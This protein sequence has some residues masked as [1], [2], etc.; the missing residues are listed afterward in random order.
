MKKYLVTGYKGF[1]GSKLY[2]MLP[3]DDTVGVDLKDGHDIIDQLPNEKVEIV[4]HM[5]AMPSVE[6]SVKY[7]SYTLKHNVLGTSKVLEWARKQ[8]AARVIFSSSA[9]IY[10]NGLGPTSPYGLHKLMSEKEC[11][12]Y[13]ELYGLDT[14]C[15][16][17][18]NVYSEDQP[19]SGA[20]ST[21]I[22]AWMEMLRQGKPLRIDGDG[23]QTRDYVHVEDVISANMFC[24]NYAG[25]FGGK[26]Y[27][28]ATGQN[29]SINNLKSLISSKL[30]AE[31]KWLYAPGRTGDVKHSMSRTI[32]LEKIG[33]SSKVK[34][35]DGLKKCFEK[36][37][38]K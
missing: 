23:D 18:F 16:R 17:Y 21:V 38:I 24:A 27:D 1:I 34:I 25:L 26:A 35:T 6:Y 12:L 7:P 33:W 13:T 5:A 4:F 9:A 29:T 10:G 37:I 36:R 3:P 11:K 30:G 22:S 28:V 14:V 15:L 19:Y 31:A 20:Y 2:D 8:G 32:D